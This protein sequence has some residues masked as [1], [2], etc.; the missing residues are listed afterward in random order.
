MFCMIHTFIYIFSKNNEL[1]PEPFIRYSVIIFGV[2][3][4][5]H[6]KYFL[7]DLSLSLTVA[8][9]AIPLVGVGWVESRKNMDVLCDHY[10]NGAIGCGL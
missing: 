10:R 8:F 4:V 6:C 5:I 9:I 7:N 2:E 1:Y 3:T